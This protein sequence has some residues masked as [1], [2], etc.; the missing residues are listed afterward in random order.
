MVDFVVVGNVDVVVDLLSF[1]VNDAVDDAVDDCVECFTETV[2]LGLYVTCLDVVEEEVAR[3]EL[4]VDTGRAVV[5]VVGLVVVVDGC[6]VL[7][8]LI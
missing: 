2:V 3:L 4:L 1:V 7:V 8:V 6:A 5:R